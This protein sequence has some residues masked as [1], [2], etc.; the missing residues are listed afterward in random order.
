MY[1]GAL[2][3][4]RARRDHDPALRSVFLLVFVCGPGTE[5]L[6]MVA[7][8]EK[9]AVGKANNARDLHEAMSE[10]LVFIF[11]PPAKRLAMFS[12]MYV[13]MSVYS[14]SVC[15]SITFESLDVEIYFWNAGIPPEDARQVRI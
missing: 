3:S 10:C 6:T 9:V 13:Y 15:N 5:K 4:L 11:L 2:S 7:S 14:M 12:V 8:G 1:E